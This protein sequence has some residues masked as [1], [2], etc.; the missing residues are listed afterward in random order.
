MVIFKFKNFILAVSLLAGLALFSSC[1]R[2]EIS[3]EIDADDVAEFV[4]ASLQARTAGLE[5]LVDS[6]VAKVED[7]SIEGICDSQYQDQWTYTRQGALIN[8][9]Y[10]SDWTFLLS[11]TA[12]DLPE[13]ANFTSD[14]SAEYGTQ[15]ISS[16]DSV[17]FDG[18]VDG[19]KISEGKFSL[20]ADYL[21]EGTQEL[22]TGA[23]IYDVVS[24]LEMDVIGL[25]IQKTDYTITT[26][27]ATFTFE[28][29]IEGESFTFNGAIVFNGNSTATVTINNN[30]YTVDLDRF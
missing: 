29:E 28:G 16:E 9:S 24:T 12:L 1:D 18:T 27:T 14:A 11:C 23:E 7:F 13:M 17:S 2:V 30:S 19:L 22:R 4:E 5:A 20:N 21:R 3:A 10:Q 8:G 6:L 15:R 25:Q 26:G